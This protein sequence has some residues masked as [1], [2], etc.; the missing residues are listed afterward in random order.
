MQVLSQ[1]AFLQALGYAIANSLW[2]AA[3]LWLIVAGVNGLFKISSQVK[4]KVALAAQFSVFVWFLV[5]L[6]FYYNQC[7]QAIAQLRYAGLNGSNAFVLQPGSHNFSSL[8]LSAIIKGEKLLPYLSIAYLCL[9]LLLAARWIN[10]YRQTTLIK[11]QGLQ[12]IDV[13]WRLFV[14]RIADMLNI[15]HTVNIYVSEL[16]KSPLTI[17]FLKPL[18]LIPLA[19]I[20]NLT[21]YQLEAVILH[22]LAHIKRADY[23]INIIQ[24]IIETALFFNPFTQLLGK[25]IKRERENSCDDWVLQFQYDPTKYA[26]ALLRIA[27]LQQAPAFAMNA[28]GKEN[29]L[30][31][32]V[33][34][35]LNQRQRTF[36][37]RN[38][39]FALLLIT[40]LLSSVAWFNPPVKQTTSA[41]ASV[42]KPK[43]VVVEPLATKIDNPFFNPV[44]FLNKPF[45]SEVKQAMQDAQT[46]LQ[47]TQYAFEETG[48]VIEKVV[49]PVLEK[50]VPAALENVKAVNLP[51]ILA[52]AGNAV[53]AGLS[54]WTVSDDVNKQWKLYTD[55]SFNMASLLSTATNA[56][57][58]VDL[59]KLSKDI[60]AVQQ[61]LTKQLANK[62]LF[63][64]VQ[65][66][67]LKNIIS[68]TIHDVQQSILNIQQSPE[69]K[70]NVSSGEGDDDDNLHVILS[71][72][73]TLLQKNESSR[74]IKLQKIQKK[75]DEVKKTID[76]LRVAANMRKLNRQGLELYNDVTGLQ[77]YTADKQSA[78]WAYGQPA[79]V[80]YIQASY[81]QNKDYNVTLANGSDLSVTGKGKSTLIAVKEEQDNAD[82]YKKRITIQTLDSTGVKHVFHLTVEVYQ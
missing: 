34:R 25:I 5:T 43:A 77:A 29:D 52:Q 36:Q 46:G 79:A 31:W 57:K 74:V 58:T 67:K 8:M 35:M 28:A 64:G 55:S 78:A 24:S 56:L 41:T 37:Y 20:N 73:G 4:Y 38:R 60:N 26:E 81:D 66:V 14:K 13:E 76:S 61:D 50:V 40:G 63:A 62:D 19:S 11:T 12:K 59:N 3:L 18:I 72:A 9:L 22:E 2:Q 53:N 7:S 65:G 45:K 51:A 75:Y 33:K 54:N 15:K 21:T 42:T 27:Y 16:V 48:D 69:E 44:F 10:G 30:L 47:A 1:S 80:N 6:Q 32:R 70:S 82:S 49:P 68:N 71:P 17:G 39:L 23:I